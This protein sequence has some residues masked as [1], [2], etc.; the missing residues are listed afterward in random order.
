MKSYEHGGQV[1]WAKVPWVMEMEVAM[2]ARRVMEGASILVLCAMLASSIEGCR[3][4][5]FAVGARADSKSLR[6]NR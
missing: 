2:R 4:I 1:N 3:A 5:G 6:L